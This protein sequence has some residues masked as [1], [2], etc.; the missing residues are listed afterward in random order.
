MPR[1]GLWDPQ[2]VRKAVS[3]LAFQFRS[4]VQFELPPFT[5]LRYVLCSTVQAC[6][7]I[8]FDEVKQEDAS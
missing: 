1:V 3:A 6:R 4:G 8:Y 2:P 5:A 7:W